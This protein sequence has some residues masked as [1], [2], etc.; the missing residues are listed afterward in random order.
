[1]RSPFTNLVNT[2]AIMSNSLSIIKAEDLISKTSSSRSETIQ[3][4][5]FGKMKTRSKKPCYWKLVRKGYTK[6]NSSFTLRHDHSSFFYVGRGPDCDFQCKAGNI[7]RIHFKLTCEIT[8]TSDNGEEV[9]WSIQD[10]GSLAGTYLNGKR[11]SMDKDYLLLKND[12][13]ALAKETMSPEEHLK[14][15]YTFVYQVINDNTF[16]D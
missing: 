7:S 5:S 3:T 14:E 11:L 6:K 4:P 13:I 16:H 15:K 9:H 12:I 1:M 2:K 10:L 8:R